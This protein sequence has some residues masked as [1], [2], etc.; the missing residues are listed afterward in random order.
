MTAL[1]SLIIAMLIAPQLGSL[2]EVFQFIQ[3]YTGVVSPGILAVFLMGLFYKKA[4]NNAAIWGVISSVPVA[5]YFK[6][7]PSNWFLA[8]TP[9]MNQMGITCLAT[10]F[11]IFAISYLEGNKNNPKGISLTSKLFE[12]SS[13]FNISAMAICIITAFL[14]AFLW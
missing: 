4:T 8:Q 10:I 6:V 11:I 2:G 1:V 3:E 12:T 14:Y 13:S 9:F 7:V 5:M